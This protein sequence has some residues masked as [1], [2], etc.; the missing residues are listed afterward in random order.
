MT[1]PLPEAISDLHK[2]TI[3][4]RGYYFKA[5]SIRVRGALLSKLSR[6]RISGALRPRA[7]RL[8]VKSSWRTLQF[9]G[10]A[11]RSW[12][13]GAG[14]VERLALDALAMIEAF[15]ESCATH[16]GMRGVF[17]LK[18]IRGKST[19]PGDVVGGLWSLRRSPIWGAAARHWNG[20]SDI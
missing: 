11:Q 2:T 10:E 5:G 3:D 17:Q 8:R 18:R 14:A 4:L 9:G 15:Y 1:S 6:G 13:H 16:A 7:S 20:Y 19:L 12:P